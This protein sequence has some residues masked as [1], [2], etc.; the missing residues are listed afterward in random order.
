MIK[1]EGYKIFRTVGPYFEG[2]PVLLSPRS[3]AVHVLLLVV[4]VWGEGGG[5]YERSPDGRVL[6]FCMIRGGG[7]G[8]GGLLSTG[9]AT[10]YV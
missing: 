2:A 10:A 6:Y 4:S 5:G 3:A 9:S 7:A 1:W 8:E